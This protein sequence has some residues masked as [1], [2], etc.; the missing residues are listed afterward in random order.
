MYVDNVLQNSKLSIPTTDITFS[1]LHNTPVIIIVPSGIIA[2]NNSIRHMIVTLIELVVVV[3]LFFLFCL[4]N[5]S[6][7]KASTQRVMGANDLTTSNHAYDPPTRM[8]RLALQGF[9]NT[10]V[11]ARPHGWADWHELTGHP[12]SAGEQP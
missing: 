1:K 6:V 5:Y 9:H 3:L 4:V 11:P 7:Q 2:N 12:A 10:H 8:G